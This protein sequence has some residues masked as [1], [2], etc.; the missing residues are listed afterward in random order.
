MNKQLKKDTKE[1]RDAL[2]E[3]LQQVQ[4]KKINLFRANTINYTAS[5]I[6]RSIDLEIKL[7][8]R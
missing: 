7:N 5:N 2:K 6:L 4:N 1:V 8:K 3:V